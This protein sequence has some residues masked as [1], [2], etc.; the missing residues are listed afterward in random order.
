MSGCQ[1]AEQ[2]IAHKEIHKEIKIEGKA[3]KGQRG[4]YGEPRLRDP[5]FLGEILQTAIANNLVIEEADAASD[6]DSNDG[7][8]GA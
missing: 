4:F 1:A 8:G 7:E 5:R 2:K 6:D 3:E